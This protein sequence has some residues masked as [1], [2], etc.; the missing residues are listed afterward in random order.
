MFLDIHL[1]FINWI[2][3]NPNIKNSKI[4]LPIMLGVNLFSGG[5]KSSKSN[6]IF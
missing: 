1:L 2:L 6:I 5:K 3:T 4:R